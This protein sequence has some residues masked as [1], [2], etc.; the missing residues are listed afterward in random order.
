MKMLD[1]IYDSSTIFALRPSLCM[2]KKKK[3]SHFEVNFLCELYACLNF[4]AHQL[5]L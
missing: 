2:M 5:F 3:V 4:D 1:L